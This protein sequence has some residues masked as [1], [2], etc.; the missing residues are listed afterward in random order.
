MAKK[1]SRGISGALC[2]V[3][4]QFVLQGL[5]TTRMRTSGAALLLQRPALADEDLAVDAQQVLALHA[6]L[7]R[8]AADQQ[9]PVHAAKPFVEAGGGHDAFEQR[10]TAVLQLHDQALQRGHGRLD[11]DQVQNHWLVRPEHRARGDAEQE[12]ITDLA[13]GA[14]NSN[15]NGSIH[16]FFWMSRAICGCAGKGRKRGNALMPRKSHLSEPSNPAGSFVPAGVWGVYPICS[17][18]DSPTIHRW[19]TEDVD[20][21]PDAAFWP[22]RCRRLRGQPHAD[23]PVAAG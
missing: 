10:K 2:M 23:W 9:R 12:G 19:P 11:F 13:G 20:A 3:I 16:S 4:R 14:G 7:A 18:H 15:T 5:P 21:L 17:E 8:H 6:G 1:R 22:L